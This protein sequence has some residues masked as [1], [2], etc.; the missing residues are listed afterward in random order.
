M[1][2]VITE[3]ERQSIINEAVEKA[4]LSLPELVGNLIINQIN[5]L[6]LNRNFYAKFPEFTNSKDIVASVVEYV[7]GLNPGIKYEQIL[8]QAVPIIRE[9]IKTFKA[10]DMKTANRPSRDIPQ[11]DNGEL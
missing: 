6:R 8:D 7:E 5:F 9:R 10:L 4:L 3:E 1:C 2:E 11:L